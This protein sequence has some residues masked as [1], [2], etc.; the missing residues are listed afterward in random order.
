MISQENST[1]FRPAKSL[2]SI[3]DLVNCDD[4]GAS[5]QDEKINAYPEAS[6]PTD[7][8]IVDK[9]VPLNSS[10]VH[11]TNCRNKNT[12]CSEFTAARTT[13]PD[14]NDAEDASAAA[15][16]I[17]DEAPESDNA[18]ENEQ[19]YRKKQRRYRTTF[20][21]YQLDELEKVFCRTHYPDIFTRE[22]LALKIGLTEARIQVW[23][24]NR[25]AKFRKTE[26]VGP[27]S[28][29]IN[30]FQHGLAFPSPSV[31]LPTQ[32][33]PIHF[34]SAGMCL[35]KTSESTPGCSIPPNFSSTRAQHPWLLQNPNF[36]TSTAL[37]PLTAFLMSRSNPYYN[38]SF[39]SSN[40]SLHQLVNHIHTASA[41][42]HQQHLLNANGFPNLNVHSL[43]LEKHAFNNHNLH[44][45]NYYNTYKAL[46]SLS[47][48]NN[49]GMSKNEED[50]RV[51]ERDEA[52]P[53]P[54]RFEEESDSESKLSP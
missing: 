1:T 28:H 12:P 15:E 36:A 44:S 3:R 17:S 25:R 52:S 2:F 39:L 45:N 16:D 20:T 43:P 42:T 53:S 32:T 22:E 49:N 40:Q 26:K 8:T 18:S 50:D 27:G 51:S 31:G 37:H 6:L 33:A 9:F 46:H 35:P 19:P 41:A 54:K 23:F 30:P 47:Q 21:S 7:S 10:D 29:P 38:Y 4:E 13:S 48:V 11:D 5:S 14:I 24:Q 34:N